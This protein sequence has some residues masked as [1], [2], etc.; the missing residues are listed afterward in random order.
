MADRFANQFVTFMRMTPPQRRVAWWRGR[1]LQWMG[2]AL[3]WFWLGLVLYLLRP[4]AFSSALEPYS[5]YTPNLA[6][7]HGMWSWCCCRR[8]QRLCLRQ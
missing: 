7:A 1:V 4:V 6:N 3:S 5:F 8:S 2:V